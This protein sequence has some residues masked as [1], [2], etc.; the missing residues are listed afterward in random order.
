MKI[1]LDGRLMTDR[2]ALHDQLAHRCAFPEYY[3]R[4]LDALY[5]LLTDISEPTTVELIHADAI[6]E[7]LGAYG[8]AFLVTLSQ[9]QENTPSL[10]L[11][12]L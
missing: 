4:N 1:C 9:A 5:D 2:A 11:E 10:S 7:H 3:G 8:A 6:R 12:I